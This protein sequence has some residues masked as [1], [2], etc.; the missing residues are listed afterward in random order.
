MLH[1]PL[2]YTIPTMS[3]LV[4]ITGG[5]GHIGF[6]VIVDTLK[7]G[8]SVRAAVR[9]QEKAN[10][11]LL[12]PSI[13]AL[14]SGPRLEFVTIPNLLVDGAYDEA[15]KGATYAIHVASPIEERHSEG[16]SYA[17]TLVE[18]AIRGTLN[19][20]EAAKQ[21]GTIRRVVITSSI[22]AIVPENVFMS[23]SATIF[24]EKNRTPSVPGPY[25]NTADAYSAGKIAALNGTEAW[26]AREKDAIKFDVVNI[27]PGFVLGRNE[28]I[29]SA[30]DA[31]RGTNKVVLGPVTGLDVGATPG[32]SVHLQ[33][34]AM[35]HVKS[36]NPEVPG[37]RGY[38]LISGGLEGTRWED[39]F[40]VVER[41]FSEAVKVGDIPNS[42]KISSIPLKIDTSETEKALGFRHRSFEEQVK[43]VVGHYLE[44]KEASK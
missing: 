27:F 31:I 21:T 44:L 39:M 8:Y 22:E 19:M 14:D 40:E 24:N 10:K 16:A 43:D 26:I 41:H 30:S 13:K 28:F 11:I 5:T 23:G 25:H 42:G 32:F 18:P 4:F 37:N 1:S 12:T 2:L 33:D 29:T 15:I 20:L 9:S 36:L 6:R 17:E 35:A 7:A 38:L 34:V 3:N